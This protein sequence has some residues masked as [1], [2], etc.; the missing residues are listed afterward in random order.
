M[1]LPELV[2]CASGNKRFAQI[3]IDAG[4][5]YG[6]QLPGTVYTDV[7]PLWFADQNWKKPQ[8]D[9]YMAALEKHRPVQATVLDLEFDSQ[10][11][12]VLDWAEEAAQYV[13]RVVIIPKAFGIID[14]LPKRIGGKDVILGYSVPTKYAGTGVP[15][16]EFGNWPIHLLGGSPQAQMNLCRYLNVVSTDGNYAM[17]MAVMHCQFWVPG[18]ARYAQNKFWPTIA[19]ANN[20][21]KEIKDA[22]YKAFEMSCHNIMKAWMAL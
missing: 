12:E 17:K 7:A 1:S 20:G 16:W 3:A 4:F 21:V 13:E 15:I 22:V 6:A 5:K 11:A 2:Y 9:S 10:L 8:R 14:K 18:T 19:E